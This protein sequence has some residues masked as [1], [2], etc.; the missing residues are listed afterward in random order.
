[1][2]QLIAAIAMIVTAL[3][4]HE[5]GH[6]VEAR[7][8]GARIGYMGWALLPGV[9]VLVGPEAK[10][11]FQIGLPK[12]S[13]DRS[14]LSFRDELW[15]YRVGPAMAL[16]AAVLL[17]LLL[18]LH[19]IWWVFVLAAACATGGIVPLLGIGKKSDGAQIRALKRA[20]RS[21]GEER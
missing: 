2:I 17:V 7:R 9:L 21:A 14:E 8:R 13:Y 18:Y 10:T 1:M 4:V 5:F 3:N 20:M 16:A 12:T 6:F 19:F 15:V 11:L